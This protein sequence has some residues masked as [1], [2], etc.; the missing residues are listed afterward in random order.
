MT[1]SPCRA[2]RTAL[3]RGGDASSHVAACAAC[4]AFADALRRTDTALDGSARVAATGPLPAALRTR[5]VAAARSNVAA[6]APRP[7]VAAEAPRRGLL[8]DL[9]LR[10]AAAAAVLVAGAWIVPPVFAADGPVPELSM[11]NL[12]LGDA[13]G[14][15]LASLPELARTPPGDV[16]TDPLPLAAGAAALCAVAWA[17][18]RSRRTA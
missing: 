3:V 14:A 1:R 7:T 5:I 12:G 11:P 16:P 6:A 2:A 8:L 18:T 15:R 17:V 13:L 4:G 10:A 9:C